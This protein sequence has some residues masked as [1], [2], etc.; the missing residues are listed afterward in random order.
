M[1]WL[2]ND[3]R[4]SLPIIETKKTIPQIETKPKIGNGYTK[5]D[6]ID[7]INNNNFSTTKN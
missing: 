5:M 6:P 2:N 4:N 1:D 7:M 3:N